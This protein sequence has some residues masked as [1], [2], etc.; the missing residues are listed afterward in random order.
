VPAPP[1]PAAVPGEPDR[2]SRGRCGDPPPTGRPRAIASSHRSSAS[3]SRSR[4]ARRRST[5]SSARCWPIPPSCRAWTCWSR[6]PSAARPRP[7]PSGSARSSSRSSPRVW[8]A[9]WL[10]WRS[11]AW[12]SAWGDSQSGPM[13]SRDVHQGPEGFRSR[14][15]TASSPVACR[16]LA[17]LAC[18]ALGASSAGLASVRPPG[19]LLASGRA[20]E[21]PF[22]QARF[23]RAA[24]TSVLA[25]STRMHPP[26][27]GQRRA[28]TP[29]TRCRSSAHRERL[30]GTLGGVPP[31]RCCATVPVTARAAPGPERPGRRLEFTAMVEAA[32]IEPGARGAGSQGNQALPTRDRGAIGARD[33]RRHFSAR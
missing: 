25:A 20:R 18:P 23:R 26:Q 31:R 13:S 4:T 16:Q 5:N 19:R 8:V 3:T 28:S 22:R 33:R 15:G 21:G 17:R 27:R 12:T 32:G 29:K 24:S 2:G 10:W 30:V 6:Y 1:R 11:G 7:R 9:A 14:G